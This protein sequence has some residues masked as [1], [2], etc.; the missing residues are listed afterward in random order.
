[1]ATHRMTSA[2]RPHAA[3]PDDTVALD[4]TGVDDTVVLPTMREP[5]T[6][7]GAAQ[8][9]RSNARLGVALKWSYLLTTGGYAVVAVLTFVLASIL[10]PRE[11]GV[12]AM[13][14]VWV[15][16]ALVLLQHGPTMAVIQQ[17]DITDDH[18][19]AAF[20]STLAGAVGF[21]AVFAALAPLWAA[22]NGLPELTPVCLALTP[23]V[24][25]TATNVI[26]DAVLRRRMQ[27]RGIAIRS[28][29]ANLGGGAAGI[30]CAIAGL[31]VW[32]LVVQQITFPILYGIMLWSITDWRPR[33]GPIRQQLRDIRRTSLQTYGGAVGNYLSLRSDVLVMGLFFGPV[34]IG[35]YRFAARFAEMAVD[36]TASG[37]HQVSLP[38]LARH[39]QDRRA[40][41][42]ELGR[43]MHGT[44]VLA[45]PALGIVA[46]VAEPLVLFIGDQWADAAGALQI[47]CLV[48]GVWMVGTLCGQGLQAAQRAGIPALFTWLTMGGSVI[49]IVVASWL[50]SGSD[51]TTKLLAAAWAML[52]TQVVMN[53][54]LVYVTYRRVLRV[55]F[56]P[57]LFGALPGVTA[58]IAAAVAGGAIH[59]LLDGALND[60]LELVV[61]GT[62][63]SAAAGV[64]LLALDREVRRRL[65]QLSGR[66]RRRPA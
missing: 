46:G 45:C 7:P 12:L 35:L 5:E 53:A 51:T 37:L 64:T 23:M 1:M 27:M 21:S 32:S 65:R 61:S 47:L 14:L 40:L 60:F 20:W 62:A 48:S 26:P 66:L 43:L 11:F 63:A 58:G 29:L 16:L 41:G 6:P 52:V 49:G 39:S 25:I 38:H 9:G 34:V 4:L 18:V 50:S 24:L 42:H 57:T 31:G 15:A 10:S 44:A 28:L 3:D 19:N 13:A 17:D 54:A 59:P 55:S 8:V 56:R 33:I 36:L 22:V 2:G 30:G